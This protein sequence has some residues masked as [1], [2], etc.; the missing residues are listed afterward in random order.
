MAGNSVYFEDKLQMLINGMA[1]YIVAFS[2]HCILTRGYIT[3]HT[4]YT[5][6]DSGIFFEG[7]KKSSIHC[8]TVV[9]L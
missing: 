4:A 9:S 1:K 5:N 8:S 7:R 6:S 3:A 2:T